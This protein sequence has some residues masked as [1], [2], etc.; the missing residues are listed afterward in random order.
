MKTEKKIK[1]V[2]AWAVVGEE[3][4]AIAIWNYYMIYPT[5]EAAKGD[6]EV[7]L[8]DGDRLIRVLITPLRRAK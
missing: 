6:R 5:R 2:K 7:H 8:G 3:E 1:A 4:N